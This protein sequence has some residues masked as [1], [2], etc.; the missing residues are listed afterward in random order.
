MTVYDVVHVATSS[1]VHVAQHTCRKKE[2]RASGVF[3]W[4]VATPDQLR[5]FA[6]VGA[7]SV[8][9]DGNVTLTAEQAAMV[10]GL[11]ARAKQPTEAA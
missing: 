11:M 6:E 9:I 1:G 10:N 7:R 8:V 2:V 4:A 3:S 5:H